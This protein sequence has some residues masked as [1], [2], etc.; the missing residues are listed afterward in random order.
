MK[1]IAKAQALVPYTR[2]W[3]VKKFGAFALETQA[4]TGISAVAI[5]AQAALESGWGKYAPGNMFF[6]VKDTDGRN[7]NEQLITTTEYF[8]NANQG[9]LFPLVIS[10]TPCVRN[11]QKWF[12][13]KVKDW[14]RKFATPEESFTHHAGFFLKN[15]RYAKALAVKQ[16]PYKFIDA[17][18]AAGYATAPDY[19][20][21]LKSVAAGIEKLL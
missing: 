20:K 10:I 17:I 19:A 11:G 18:A 3:F 16:D 6:G 9:H 7:N 8:R 14:F 21:T 5:L 15:P 4:K 13:Y 1:I 2:A 12:K